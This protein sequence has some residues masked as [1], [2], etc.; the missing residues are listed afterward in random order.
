MHKTI[1]SFDPSSTAIGWAVFFDEKLKGYGVC[2]P[3]NKQ[4]HYISRVKDMLYQI[5]YLVSS[6]LGIGQPATLLVETPSGHVHAKKKSSGGHGQSIYGFAVGAVYMD[7]C[8][9]ED[10]FVAEPVDANDWTRGIPKQTR[11]RKIGL[12]YPEYNPKEDKGGDA[13]D[14][15]GMALWWMQEEK[16]RENA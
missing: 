12:L 16:V 15:I 11:T 8:N 1:I 14:A 4:A 6:V 2:R 5:D 10:H 3:T 13:A 9:Y 7:F